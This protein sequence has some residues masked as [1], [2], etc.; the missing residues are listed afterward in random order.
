MISLHSVSQYAGRGLHKVCIFD[1]V[2]LTVEPGAKLVVLGQPG[3]GKTTFL[4]L[5]AGIKMPHV[6]RIERKGSVSPLKGLIRYGR[7]PITLRQLLL[8]FSRIYRVEE[9]SL[10]DFV[11]WFCDLTIALDIS[12]AALPPPVRRNL[13]FALIYGLPFDF[14]LFDNGLFPRQPEMRARAQAVLEMRVRRS[15]LIYATS[16]ARAA[17]QLEGAGAVIHNRKLELYPSVAEAVE[18]FVELPKTLSLPVQETDEPE[19]S[20]EVEI[21]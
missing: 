19:S 8:K 1:Q 14:Y 12:V 5:L 6:G 10:I 16:I 11:R 4:E 21:I 13:D 20:F 2:S 7:P 15:G 3:T 18:A 9:K 17:Q